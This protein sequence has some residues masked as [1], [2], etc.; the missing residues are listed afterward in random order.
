M[1]R[2]KNALR[3]IIRRCGVQSPVQTLMLTEYCQGGSDRGLSNVQ[4]DLLARTPFGISTKYCLVL[5]DL[6]GHHEM[7]T[8]SA[9]YT[10]L[11]PAKR[12][13]P[14]DLESHV[15]PQLAAVNCQ[16]NG[17]HPLIGPSDSN[18]TPSHQHT[19]PLQFAP[20][21]ANAALLLDFVFNFR[22]GSDAGC[23]RDIEK[24]SVFG[25]HR[26][27]YPSPIQ[28]G[29]QLL[30]ITRHATVTTASS[31]KTFKPAAGVLFIVTATRQLGWR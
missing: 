27:C 30:P 6:S 16:K 3:V 22:S 5:R 18:T 21:P 28:R 25:L 26:K 29:N 12:C 9:L 4:F 24:N 1:C 23:S 20:R 17:T 7:A 2:W 31:V 11:F 13:D 10:L 19:Q 8:H 14:F 15:A